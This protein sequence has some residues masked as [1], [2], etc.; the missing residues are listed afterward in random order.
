MKKRSLLVNCPN[1]RARVAADVRGED[2]YVGTNEAEEVTGGLRICILRCS[3]CSDI[4]ASVQQLQAFEDGI[5]T[6]SDA[7][8]IWPQP[9][10]PISTSIPREIRDSLLEAEGCLQCGTYTASVAMIG[11]ALEAVGRHFGQGK[12]KR[13]M[14]W[15]GITNLHKDRVID[16]RLFSWAKELHEHRNLAVHATAVRLTRV[17]AEDLFSFAHSLCD[18][19][20]V[21]Q[22][23][24]DAFIQRK[25]ARKTGSHT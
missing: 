7:Q 3:T 12:K 21:L 1:C 17:D 20:F 10:T 19:V 2:S 24:Y 15:D 25:K 23:R 22:T 11:R 13:L 14:L 18:Y 6:W 4:L 16:D 5:E 8:R 9:P